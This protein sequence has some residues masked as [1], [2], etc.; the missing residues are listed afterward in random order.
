MKNGAVHK[1]IPTGA[2][3]PYKSPVMTGFRIEAGQNMIAIPIKSRNLD[4]TYR[5]IAN[6]N[7]SFKQNYRNGIY[8]AFEIFMGSNKVITMKAWTCK[9]EDGT[10]KLEE[11]YAEISIDNSE[12]SKIKTKFVAPIG[13][14][15]NPKSEINNLLQLVQNFEKC[16]NKVEKSSLAKRISTSV[17][18]ITCSGNKEEFADVVLDALSNVNSEEGRTRLFVI[19]RKLSP[20]W[21]DS[22]KSRLASRCIG[23]LSADLQGMMI[24]GGPKVSTNIQAVYTLSTCANMDQLSKLANLH[25]STRYLQACLYTHAKTRSDLQWIQ[26]ELEKDLKNA[27]KG[28]SNNLQFSAHAIGVALR[29]VDGQ[30]ILS[31]K[32]ETKI[33]SKLTEVIRTGNLSTE[34]LNSTILAIGCICDQ[35]EYECRIEPAVITDALL[36]IRNIGEV[37]NYLIVM[38]QQKACEVATKMINGELLTNDEEQ[39]LLTKLG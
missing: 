14:N 7:I 4:G 18:S 21:S 38:A 6:G 28:H 12:H 1:I 8:V 35:R 34:E 13:S 31:E 11:G 23:Q 25:D 39:F 5:I 37:Y 30:G 16:R 9:D 27:T 17:Q 3:L 33:V 36:A 24:S 29:N 2:E 26:D 22:Q 32:T 20:F 10:E 15:L 19:A